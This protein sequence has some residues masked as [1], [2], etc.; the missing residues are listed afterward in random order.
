MELTTKDTKRTEWPQR[1]E[2][3]GKQVVDSAFKV[4]M[5]LGPGLLE[6]VYETCLARELVKRQVEV[7]RQVL[8]PIIYDGETIDPAMKLDL[9]VG[10]EVI[11][12]VKAVDKTSLFIKPNS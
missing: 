6:S 5:E 4:H 3:L 10:G 7:S 8:V 2:A 12:E 9:L 11:V 1:L